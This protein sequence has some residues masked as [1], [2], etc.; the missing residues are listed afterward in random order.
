MSELTP[1]IAAEVIAA[2][3][4]GAE[5]AAGALGR[6][7][8]GEFT[9]AVG[10]AGSYDAAA[11]PEGFDGPGLAV[12]FS[13]G[14]TGA[15]ALLP[16]ATGLIPDWY[17]DPDP[18]GASKLSTLAQELSMLLV[19]ET[20]MADVFEARRVDNLAAALQ[21][22]GVAGDAAL[23][24]LTLSR[25]DSS[26]VMTLVWPLAEPAKIFPPEPEPESEPE[27]APTPKPEA[28]ARPKVTFGGAAAG[29]PVPPPP[30]TTHYD[31]MMRVQVPVSVALA[32]KKE[33]VQEIIEL[34]PG[35][36]LKFDK[37]CDELLHLFAGGQVI[38][39]GEAV[40][41]G[42]KFGFRVS[43]MVLPEERFVSVNPQPREAG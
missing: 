40:K 18:T 21:G 11:T 3:Q 26:G 39:E 24:P 29:E 35:T 22:A 1:Q 42:E 30:P 5:E 23:A 6:A 34:A 4:A 38:A 8:D 10:E 7:L 25:G 12:M 16:E 37:S 32:S 13:F 15:A 31:S 2:C 41:V 28:P 36:I 9:V 17:G 14:G 27:P 43:A 20:L 19:P 33:S